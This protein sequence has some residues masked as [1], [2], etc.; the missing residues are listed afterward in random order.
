[1]R[2]KKIFTIL[3]LKNFVC[4]VLWSLLWIWPREGCCFFLSTHTVFDLIN[5]HAPLRALQVLYRS[6]KFTELLNSSQSME[7]FLC[8]Y[9]FIRCMK[10]SVDPDQLASGEVS[11]SGPEVKKLFSCSTRLSTKFQ[12]HIKTKILTNKEVSWLS[13]VVFIMLMNVKMP[14]IVGILTF[15]RRI[16]FVL[17]W[18]EHEKKKS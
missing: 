9:E 4:L 18:V 17:S 14:T 13:D 1:M 8:K 12:L 5:A 16:I 15:M 10:N 11:W 3:T 7:Q 6:S 2:S